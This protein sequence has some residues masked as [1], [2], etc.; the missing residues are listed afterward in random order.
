MESSD[1]ITVVV[2]LIGALSS[3]KAWEYYQK[4]QISKQEEKNKELAETHLYRDDLR[5]EV[6]RLRSKLEESYQ[7][8]QDEIQ[9]LQDQI[10]ELREQLA[11]F[12]TRVEFLEKENELLRKSIDE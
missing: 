6:A 3:A 12:R 9:A 1:I 11:T 4:K 5:D 7:Q 10:A 2:T 8:K